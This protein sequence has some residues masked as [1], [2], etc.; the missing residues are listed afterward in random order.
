M[1]LHK[2]AKEWVGTSRLW[3]APGEDVHESKTT[4]Q[5]FSTGQGQFDVIS[6]MWQFEDEPQEGM[7][8]FRSEMDGEKTRAVWLDSWHMRSDIMVCEGSEREGTVVLRGSYAA[9]P[10]PD[11][12]WRIEIER[13][14]PSALV[15]RMFNVTPGGKEAL[16]VLAEY[17]ATGG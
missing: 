8:I 11:W 14:Q 2:Q 1:K 16:A 13:G 3:L 7:I 4:A 15:I 6:Y 12:G 10:G 5:V 9:P 17:A